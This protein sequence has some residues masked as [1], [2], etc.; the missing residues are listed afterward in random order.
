MADER[1]LGRSR[2]LADI[3]DSVF[4]LGYHPHAAGRR[5]LMQIRSRHAPAVWNGDNA[6]V[7]TI[8]TSVPGFP[9][10]AFDARFSLAM[11]EARREMICMAH[12]LRTDESLT[13]KQIAEKLDVSISTI[14]R[15]LKQWS[16][17]LE[18]VGGEQPAVDSALE[19]DVLDDYE[20]E[21]TEA[22][23]T[24]YF[25]DIGQSHLRGKDRP[26]ADDDQS[27]SDAGP[28]LT[29]IPLGAGM[30]RRSIYDLPS[31][32][33]KFGV[34]YYVEKYEHHTNRPQIFYHV[35]KSGVMVRH[36]R[37]LFAI[38]CKNLGP[39]PWLPRE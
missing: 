25:H 6:P 29:R 35:N 3:A 9:A 36:E 37:K 2:V 13:Y 31:Y 23:A 11:D 22:E 19:K 17:A 15:L 5:C 8:E 32:T 20:E 7:S 24:R 26:P 4:A 12:Q 18:D 10:L 1:D 21:W 27:S 34:T 30:G 39:P 14:G 16:P 33:D 38:F 28:D